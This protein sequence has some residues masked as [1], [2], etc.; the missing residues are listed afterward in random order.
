MAN[1]TDKLAVKCPKCGRFK[2]TDQ[3]SPL[4]G[5]PYGVGWT[6]PCPVDGLDMEPVSYGKGGACA[7]TLDRFEY[8]QDR[9]GA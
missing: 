5:D 7:E 2:L 3:V 6:V 1:L 9:R 4:T 8:Y